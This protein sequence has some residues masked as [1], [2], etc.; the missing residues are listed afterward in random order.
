MSYKITIEPSGLQISCEEGE[1]ILEAA[2]RNGVNLH[3][4][5]RNAVCGV[6]KGVLLE[7]SVHYADFETPGLSE[8]ERRQSFALFCRAIPNSDVRIE[9]EH[10][11]DPETIPIKTLAATVE[12]ISR[13]APDTILLQLRPDGDKQLEFLAGQYIDILMQDGR[14]RSFSIANAPSRSSLIDLHI[15]HNKNGNYTHYIFNEMQENESLQ[16][17]GPFGSFYFR[18]QSK[19]PII[20][21]AGGTGFGPIKAIIEHA[22]AEGIARP[23][24]LYRGA[25]TAADLYMEDIIDTWLPQSNMTYIPVL[26]EAGEADGWEGRTGLVHEAIAADFDDLQNYE[27][28]SCGPPAMVQA[29]RSAF[30]GR[31]LT[32]ER[33]YCDA[34]EK[35]KD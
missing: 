7:G 29:G 1:S 6:C 20:F 17:E 24:Y 13:L 28:Y 8:T 11:I 9:A 23:M 4:G 35:A 19:R 2:L 21:M 22:L 31:G 33:Y 18:E 15:R 12:T 25:R 32:E 26:S 34:F 27:V 10:V 16:I 14:R 3:Y 5:C 30:I